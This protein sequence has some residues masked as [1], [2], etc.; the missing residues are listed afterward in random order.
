MA[1]AVKRDQHYHI[2]KTS[3]FYGRHRMRA[4]IGRAAA[5]AAGGAEGW[6]QQ[7]LSRLHLGTWLAVAAVE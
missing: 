4:V 2:L 7:A 3:G 5:A 6:R 1:A